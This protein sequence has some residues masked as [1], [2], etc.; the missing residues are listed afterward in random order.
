LGYYK[1][2]EEAFNAYKKAKEAYIKEVAEEWRDSID[3][4]VYEALTNWVVEITD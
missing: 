4:R 2:S 1:T 3:S